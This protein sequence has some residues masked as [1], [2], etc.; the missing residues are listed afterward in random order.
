[1][2]QKRG[3]FALWQAIAVI[4]IL[5]GIMVVTMRFAS[6][7]AHHT[8][9]SYTKEQAELFLRSAT[10]IAM[11]QISGHDRSGGCLQRVRVVSRDRK[12][13]ADI[14]ITRY[15]LLKSSPDFA[16]CG[17]LAYPIESEESHGMV[18]METVVTSDPTNP[19]VVHPVR[20][21]RRGIQRP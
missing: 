7:G 20:I 16:L 8:A 13:T 1:M 12:F 17:P 3:A 19:R 15:Y 11:L 14:N 4:L 6:I 10:E 2:R 9:D 18:M 21:I 5:G